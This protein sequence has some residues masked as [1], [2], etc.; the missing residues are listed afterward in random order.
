MWY[1]SCSGETLEAGTAKPP[2]SHPSFCSEGLKWRV[3]FVEKAQ[4]NNFQLFPPSLL[5]TFQT[6]WP[7]STEMPFNQSVLSG[8]SCEQSPEISGHSNNKVSAQRLLKSCMELVVHLRHQYAEAATIALPPYLN[9]SALEWRL[10]RE[11]GF[12]EFLISILSHKQIN[13]GLTTPFA[14][15]R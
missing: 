15:I 10:A 1:F 14:G 12:S 2:L 7:F 9:N 5:K 4:I 13:K 3:C 8:C 6:S 11:R